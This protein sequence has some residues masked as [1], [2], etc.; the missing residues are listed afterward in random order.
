MC[1]DQ[2]SIGRSWVATTSGIF[3]A[4]LR[5]RC[6]QFVPAKDTAMIHTHQ[7]RKLRVKIETKECELPRDE[8]PRIDESLNGIVQSVGDLPGELN[9]TIVRH[10]RTARFHVEAALSLPRR[11]LFT[12]DWDPYL[13]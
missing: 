13:D 8:L 11:T 12:G 4:L 9:L 1:R 3:L 6:N 10:P 2:Q 7:Q 5:L